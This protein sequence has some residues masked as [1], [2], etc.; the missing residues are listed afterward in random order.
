MR[1]QQ[2]AFTLI[3]LMTGILILAVLVG[4]A[5]PSFSS[6]TANS[7]VTATTNSLVTALN[8]A[9]SE[10]MRRS[11]PVSVCASTDGA[12]CAFAPTT[13]A[14]TYSWSGGWIVFT[15]GTGSAGKL[16]G[17]DV[18]LQGWPAAGG[19]LTASFALPYVQ[20][21]ARGMMNLSSVTS[22]SVYKPGCT[23]AHLSQLSVSVVGSLQ[24][25]YTNCP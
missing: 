20:Y 9:R 5:V 25:S 11:T 23:G 12:T 18:L 8:L 4:L 6:F 16:D 17:T 22:F 15:D 2:R 1:A 13:T 7:R 21:D 14:G 19:G 10:S 24:S 3:E